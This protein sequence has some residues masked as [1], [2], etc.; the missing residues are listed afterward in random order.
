AGDGVDTV[1][2]NGEGSRDGG[3]DSITIDGGAGH[4]TIRN[5]MGHYSSLVGGAGNDTIRNEDAH[6]V[7]IDGGEEKDIISS[8]GD[9]NSIDGGAGDDVITNSGANV[10]VGGGT[11]ND[12]ISNSGA[13]VLFIY[14]GGNDI[15]TGFNSTS[16]L[17]I[18]TAQSTYSKQTS[19]NDLIVNIG[20]NSVTLKDAAALADSINIDLQEILD[21]EWTLTDNVATYGTSKE[22][23]ITITGVKS[24]EGIELDGTVVTV[25]KSALG[26]SE[27][28][29]SDGYE[30]ALGEDVPEPTTEQNAGW[31]YDN[32]IATYKNAS[33]SAGYKLENNT[34]RHIE[35]S[36]GETLVTVS[37]VTSDSGLTLNGTIVTVSASSLSQDKVVTIS[38]GYELALADDVQKSSTTSAGWSFA[39][40]SATYKKESISA[41][42]KIDNKQIVHKSASG[43][44]ILV[45]VSGVTSDSGLSLNG[46]KVTVSASS[47][48]QDKVVTISEGYELAL[49]DDVQKSSTTPAGWSFNN[50]VATYKKEST[51]AGYKI[52]NKQIVY[53]TASGGETLVTVSGVTSDSGLT[54]NGTTVTV[55]ASSLSQDK[56][57]TISEG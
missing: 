52:D 42:Y 43:G 27:V 4:D 24:L 41:G 17:Q 5:Y 22:T 3:G 38:D 34:I 31:T 40:N 29:I 10:T 54:L 32:N 21:L 48:S 45:T 8:S 16:T 15:I 57:V 25:S 18:V 2:N 36:G 12:S 30:L 6:H 53:K 23:Y 49:A 28:T 46:T 51:S 13:N 56:V 44:E 7:T 19:E 1:N 11:G 33:T 35:A 50:D 20:Q 55:S 39:N 9:N 47:L 14:N 37:G 26:D